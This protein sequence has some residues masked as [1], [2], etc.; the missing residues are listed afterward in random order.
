MA[1][2]CGLSLAL[3]L[4]ENDIP[5][6]SLNGRDPSLLKLVRMGRDSST[7]SCCDFIKRIKLVVV[8]KARGA[9]V[10]SV[11]HVKHKAKATWRFNL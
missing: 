1:S 2:S 10:N 5:G 4:L 11:L 6:A 3:P 8:Y 9:R 7:D